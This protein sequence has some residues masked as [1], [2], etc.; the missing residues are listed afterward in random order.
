MSRTILTI[1][2]RSFTSK[3][4]GKGTGLGLSTVYGIINQSG[5]HIAV[6]SE[7]GRGSTFKVYLPL[8]DRIGRPSLQPRPMAVSLRGNETILLVEDDDAV[9]STMRLILHRQGY[10][11]VEV[12]NG[13]DALL[14]SEHYDGPIHMLLTDVV[15]PRMNG[16][17]LAERL[18]QLRPRLKCFTQR[19]A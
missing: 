19:S 5:G 12:A 3:E 11:I 18:L 7:P 13:G 2:S 14:L 10:H 8:T 4:K 15:M 9:R 17:Q 16:R 6:E 1:C